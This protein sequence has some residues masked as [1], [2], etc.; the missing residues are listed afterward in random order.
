VDLPAVEEWIRMHADPV[1][2]IET[3]YERPWATVLRVPLAAASPGSRPARRRRHSSH[4]SPPT[5][6]KTMMSTESPWSPRPSAVE[7]AVTVRT[8]RSVRK[9]RGE[10]VTV[11]PHVTEKGD[12]DH[13]ARSRL[14]LEP[15]SMRRSNVD[16][17]VKPTSRPSPLLGL[18]YNAW[19]VCQSFSKI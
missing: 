17:A 13:A 9:E 4:A 1:G 10:A 8:L 14:G 6:S 12:S 7:D 2:P 5:S 3:A 11:E 19:A 16:R 18:T 15:G